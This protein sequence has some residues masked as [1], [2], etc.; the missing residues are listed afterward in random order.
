LT[1]YIQLYMIIYKICSYINN[2]FPRIFQLHTHL[3]LKYAI[4]FYLLCSDIVFAGL[5]LMDSFNNECEI[6]GWILGG[7]YIR[8]F[9]GAG[10]LNTGI[11]GTDVW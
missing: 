7:I 3:F 10:V 9:S 5:I 6:R 2:F 11:L 8:S 4:T 1:F